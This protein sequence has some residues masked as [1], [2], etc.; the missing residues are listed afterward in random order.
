MMKRNN[1]RIA[2]LLLLPALVAV[3]GFAQTGKP[4]TVEQAVDL[5]IKNSKQLKWYNAKTEEAA[6]NVNQAKEGYLPDLKVSASYMRL[7]NPDVDLKIKLGSSGSQA[8]A[9]KVDELSYAMMNASLPLF[10]GF[11]IKYGLESAKYLEHAARLD[12]ENQQQDIVINTVSAFANLY[13][14]QKTVE[15][16]KERLKQ[17]E[18]RVTDFSNMVKNELLAKND[19][20]KAQLQYDNVEQS[21]NEAKT[22]LKIAAVNMGILLG[23]SQDTVIYADSVGLTDGMYE[24]QS[25]ADWEKTALMNRK[26]VAAL[27]QR[28][29][30][31]ETAIK[32]AKGDLLPGL[33][34]TGGFIAANIP[35]VVT[36]K[37][38]LNGGIGVQY[39]ISSLWKTSSKIAASKVRKQEVELNQGLLNDQ[40]RQQ[41]NTAYENYLLSVKKIDVYNKAVEQAEENYRISKNKFNNTV[42]SATDL[43]E[44]D[45]MDFQAKLNVT[46][47]KIDSWVA[48]KKLLYAAGK[49]SK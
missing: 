43:L 11:K 38:A 35:G 20:L 16:I 10:A 29:K 41:I 24:I 21:L 49:L 18:H 37:D 30:A 15:L 12:A 7:N 28:E 46:L 23:F 31:A 36:I 34:L 3:N 40:I 4:L 42:L 39:N 13:K 1:C 25:I 27:A 17:E 22:N 26:D 33:A 8:P 45:V 9:I 44:A 2:V 48:Y 5:S 32:L 6:A 47:V 19:L 14:A